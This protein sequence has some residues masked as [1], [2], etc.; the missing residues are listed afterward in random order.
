VLVEKVGNVIVNVTVMDTYMFPLV[1][2]DIDQYQWH[3][4]YK[5]KIRFYLAIQL[6]YLVD[7]SENTLDQLMTV[8]H[9]VT[10]N[11][12]DEP[13]NLQEQEVEGF[14]QHWDT[15]FLY[16]TMVRGL[17]PTRIFERLAQLYPTQ[18]KKL[19]QNFANEMAVQAQVKPFV[20]DLFPSSVPIH[21]STTLDI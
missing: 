7:A 2:D 3:I 11:M 15:F 4:A 20:G 12:I 13:A 10:S 5:E 21:S 18:R 1:Y 19:I 14:C 8:T 16:M 9:Y 6:L 17:D